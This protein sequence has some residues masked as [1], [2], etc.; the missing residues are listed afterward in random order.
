MCPR[1]R[2]RSIA[3]QAP[4]W[5][6]V[7]GGLAAQNQV[8]TG[9]VDSQYDPERVALP[10]GTDDPF[11]HT[12]Y[13]F[14]FNIKLDPEYEHLLGTGNF[15][16]QNSETGRLHTERES[17]TFPSWAWPD[18]GD[19]VSLVGSWIWDCDH[20]QPSGEHTEIHPFRLLWVERNPGGPSRRSAVGRQ[21]GRPLRHICRNRRRTPQAICANQTKGDRA[22]FKQ[23][24]ATPVTR[25]RLRARTSSCCRPE[26]S[27]RRKRGSST[28]WSIGSHPPFR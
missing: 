23:C 25:C 20:Y 4:N 2:T 14:T 9:I 5:V 18:R 21:R 6:Y 7:G 15:E 10:A 22:A 19:R 27:P 3:K 24:L 26:R 17:L 11:T 13:D 8:A 1:T 28:A 16:G 12:S